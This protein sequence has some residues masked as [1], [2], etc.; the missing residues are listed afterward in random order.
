MT[1]AEEELGRVMTSLCFTFR[2]EDNAD[3]FTRHQRLRTLLLAY[4]LTVAVLAEGCDMPPDAYELLRT[5]LKLA[6][7]DI[8]AR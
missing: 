5:E 4:I 1:I 7:V 6:P 3:V 8:N 2:Q